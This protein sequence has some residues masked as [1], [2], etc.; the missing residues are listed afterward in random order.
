MQQVVPQPLLRVIKLG[1]SLLTLPDLRARFEEWLDAQ[2]P[3]LNLLICG[4]GE[5]VEA[6]RRIDESQRLPASVTHWVSIDLMATT[7]ALA[8]AI[9]RLD[10]AIEAPSE[11]SS[12]LKCH[13]TSAANQIVALTPSAYLNRDNAA[14][15]LPPLPESWECTSDSIAA[16]V[17][18]KFDA[19]EIV[20]LK[21]TAGNETELRIETHCASQSEFN[22]WARTGLVDATFPSLAAS[23][24]Q[25]RIVNLR[26]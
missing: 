11:L 10:A 5:L 19:Q 25:V 2:P 1:G 23:L 14:V 26:A 18:L 17:A 7:A 22:E 20:L 24:P 16:W 12:F 6:V 8:A 13:P 3:A 4:G 9:L 15:D 21:S